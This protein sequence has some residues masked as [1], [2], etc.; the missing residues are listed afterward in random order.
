MKAL[1]RV[2]LK[3]PP[4]VLLD[5]ATSALDAESEY[6]VQLAIETIM[7]GRTVIS[8]AHRLSSMRLADRIIVLEAGKIAESGNYYDLL[9]KKGVFEQLIH[10]QL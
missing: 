1:A 9:K 7:K 4:I 3:N 5:E 6:H 10:R 2:F 8:I